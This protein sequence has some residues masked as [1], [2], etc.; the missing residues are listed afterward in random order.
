M[1]HAV[2]VTVK[3]ICAFDFALP[4]TLA[5]LKKD[6]QYD[7]TA[8]A[9]FYVCIQCYRLLVA[10]KTRLQAKSNVFF[11]LPLTTQGAVTPSFGI[12]SN[13]VTGGT[14]ASAYSDGTV[15]TVADIGEEIRWTMRVPCKLSLEA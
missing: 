4:K 5:R 12:D 6:R 11:S 14:S 2:T 8:S 10:P 13:L 15:I 1:S 7:P 9:W 3:L